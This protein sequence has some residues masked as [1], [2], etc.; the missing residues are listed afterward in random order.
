MFVEHLL[1]AMAWE[2]YL[3]TTQT[4]ATPS[5]SLPSIRGGRQIRYIANQMICSA[6]EKNKAGT[7]NKEYWV[8]GGKRRSKISK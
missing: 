4:E 3:D 7:E 6:M 5:S 2:K 1:C 8:G